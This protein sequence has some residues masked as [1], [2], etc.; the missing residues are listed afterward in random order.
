M[1][2]GVGIRTARTVDI[3]KGMKTSGSDWL[4]IDLQRGL[5]S[6]T[7]ATTI[8]GAA[9]DTGISSECR[10]ADHNREGPHLAKRALVRSKTPPG[11]GA[12]ERC[13]MRRQGQIRLFGSGAAVGVA[14]GGEKDG[15]SS[16]LLGLSSR[17]PEGDF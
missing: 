15:D 1:S 4:F 9:R 11:S 14:K 3:A 8:A 10:D 12:L 5:M 17:S 2:L 7:L 16:R 13:E 6:I